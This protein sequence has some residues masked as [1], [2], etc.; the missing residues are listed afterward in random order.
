MARVPICTTA[1]I[2][3]TRNRS[4]RSGVTSPSDDDHAYVMLVGAVQT[5]NCVPPIAGLERVMK[6][7]KAAALYAA[8]KRSK[9]TFQ[10][11]RNGNEGHKLGRAAKAGRVMA[12]A[13]MKPPVVLRGPI[14]SASGPPISA[15]P[16]DTKGLMKP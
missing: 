4:K 11:T 3:N 15:P 13:I 10:P 7:P 5:A 9:A 1:A 12:M 8:V 16:T 14:L 2:A 6:H